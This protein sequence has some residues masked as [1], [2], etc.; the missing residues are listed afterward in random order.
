MFEGTAVQPATIHAAVRCP[1]CGAGVDGPDPAA[2][3]RGVGWVELPGVWLCPT[4]SLRPDV[5][6]S[7]GVEVS[8]AGGDMSVVRVVGIPV[9]LLP[10]EQAN[11]EA[12]NLRSS[13]AA[14]VGAAMTAARR[15]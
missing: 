5:W 15:G 2:V 6:A 4:C 9:M 10:H 13:L 11:A 1:I 14:F 7:I 8:P 12:T 3:A